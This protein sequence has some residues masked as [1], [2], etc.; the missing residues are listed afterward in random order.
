M[1]WDI[2]VD[3][4]MDF[5]YYFKKFNPAKINICLMKKYKKKKRKAKGGSLRAIF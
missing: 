5:K 4:I 2:E 1:M 3:S